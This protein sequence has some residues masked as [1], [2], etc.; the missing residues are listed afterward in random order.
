MFFKKTE[1]R[2]NPEQKKPT[3]VAMSVTTNTNRVHIWKSLQGDP[4]LLNL[5]PVMK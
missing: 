1:K 5:K 3:H 4:L 2:K